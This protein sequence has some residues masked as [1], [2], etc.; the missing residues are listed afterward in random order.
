MEPKLAARSSRI[1]QMHAF[2]S[3]FFVSTLILFNLLIY[4]HVTL[5]FSIQINGIAQQ[6]SYFR[7]GMSVTPQELKGL[8]ELPPGDTLFGWYD[9]T[10]P[11]WGENFPVRKPSQSVFAYFVLRLVINRII[12]TFYFLFV[13]IM[14]VAH[15]DSEAN[16]KTAGLLEHFHFF[17]F[18]WYMVFMLGIPAVASFVVPPLVE[19][20]GTI[21]AVVLNSSLWGVPIPDNF[22]WITKVLFSLLLI[23]QLLIAIFIATQLTSFEKKRSV[24]RFMSGDDSVRKECFAPLFLTILIIALSCVC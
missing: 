16:K 19:I 5:P 23:S 6:A 18:F 13:F 9:K 4:F 22:A 21:F 1:Y 11:F 14:W 15:V 10:F 12:P 2:L 3:L 7:Y 17:F 20:P 24:M 8:Q